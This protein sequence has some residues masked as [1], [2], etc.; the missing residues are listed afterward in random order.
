MRFGG[1]EGGRDRT[2]SAVNAS[3][4]GGRGGGGHVHTQQQ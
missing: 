4:P 3:G 1:R 2:Y